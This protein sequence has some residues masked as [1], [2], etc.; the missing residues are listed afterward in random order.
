MWEN[1]TWGASAGPGH[2]DVLLY[3]S[4]VIE[5]TSTDFT[6]ISENSF[7]WMQFQ[8]LPPSSLHRSAQ[9]SKHL[10]RSRPDW[11]GLA[12]FQ[13]LAYS[14]CLGRILSHPLYFP[15]VYQTQTRGVQRKSKSSKNAISFGSKANASSI[16]AKWSYQDLT[17]DTP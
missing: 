14:G 17:R 5:F 1:N 16:L 11:S 8:G 2:S 10:L 13:C 9:Q 6:E 4:K 15:G 12:L 7:I 3:R